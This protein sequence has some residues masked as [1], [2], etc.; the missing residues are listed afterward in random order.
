MIAEPNFL[1][2]SS[3]SEGGLGLNRT[4]ACPIQPPS[5]R[6]RAIFAGKIEPRF[7]KERFGGAP[8]HSFPKDQAV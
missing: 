3:R 5:E 2:G 6:Q 8:S 4:D 7:Q 1:F